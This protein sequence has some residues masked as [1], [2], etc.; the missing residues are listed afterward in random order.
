M[1]NGQYTQLYNP[2]NQQTTV[3]SIDEQINRLQKLKAQVQQPIQQPTNLTQNFQLAPNNQ[4]GMK[5]A[6]TIEEVN[7]E[8]IFADTPFFS[9][10]M[11]VVWIK[12]L[13]GDIKSYELTEIIPKDAKDMQIEYLQ[14][15][16]NELKK[17]I[18]NYDANVR[19]V[20]E[21]QNATDTSTDDEPMGNAIKTNEST[22]IQKVSRSKAK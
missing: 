16:I 19:N 2:Y 18:K 17:G 22:S 9:K 6:N 4:G 1:Y 15:Q 7:K 14:T 3:E 11:S 10:D 8:Q 13:K 20:N 5:Y 12:D 21:K